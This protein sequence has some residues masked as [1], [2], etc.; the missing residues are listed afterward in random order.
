MRGATKIVAVMCVS[1]LLGIGVPGAVSPAAAATKKFT[2]C[3]ALLKVYKYG[4]ASTKKAKGKTKAVVSATTYKVNKKL[5]L[6]A[7]GIA[8]DADDVTKGSGS[9]GAASK[10]FTPKTY[11]G[12]DNE[13]IKVEIPS[14]FVAAAVVDFD[15]EYGVTITSFDADENMI[16]TPVSSY[17]PYSG[18][19]LLIRGEDPEEPMNIA[20]LDVAGE[21]K[22]KIKI[23]AASTLPLFKSTAEGES[24][25]VYRYTGDDTEFGL[26][27]EGEESISVAV[28][29]KDGILVERTLDEYGELD[30]TF[31]MTAGAYVVIRASAVWS[32]TLD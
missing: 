30:D 13:V 31:A 5:D 11:E 23:I 20:T 17:G 7:D 6:D 19:V 3:T 10:K 4:V 9:S 15:G 18:T 24:D 25:A 29:D 32:M 27:H 8:C 14:G 22:W 12:V 1:A 2:T 16:D 26:V 28:Y 21:G